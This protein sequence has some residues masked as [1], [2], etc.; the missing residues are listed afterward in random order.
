MG[1]GVMFI[2]NDYD[3]ISITQVLLFFINFLFLVFSILEKEKK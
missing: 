2:V 1:W 3:F